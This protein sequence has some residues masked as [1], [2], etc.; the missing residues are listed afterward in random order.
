MHH[1]SGQVEEGENTAEYPTNKHGPADQWVDSSMYKTHY[2]NE[3]IVFL[4]IS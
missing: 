3:G 4:S 2:H 1:L